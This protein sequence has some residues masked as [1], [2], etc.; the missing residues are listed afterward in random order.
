MPPKTKYVMQLTLTVI[1]GGCGNQRQATTEEFEINIGNW[2]TD[3]EKSIV[4]TYKDALRLQAVQL[5]NQLFQKATASYYKLIP[6]VIKDKDA[7]E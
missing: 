5:V 1:E 6:P 7:N 4:E 2:S 3:S